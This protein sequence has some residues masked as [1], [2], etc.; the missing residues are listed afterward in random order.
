MSPGMHRSVPSAGLWCRMDDTTFESL[1]STLSEALARVEQAARQVPADRWDDAVHTGDGGWTRRELL[2][3][4]AAND[5]RQLVRIRVG[6]GVA[7]P[8]DDAALAAEQ[9]L[10]EWN[11]ARVDER[12][13]RSV[14][15]LLDEMRAHR[16]ELL[17]LLRGL[18]PEQRARPMPY[19]GE[20]T[21][22]E[23]MVPSLVAH[24]DLHAREL[25]V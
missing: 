20:P 1:M 7:A 2:A 23:E 6:A 21:P 19:R 18:T 24:L 8:D 15:D 11:Q 12:R 22:L 17:A 16:A 14:D 3:H 13:R 4:V 25:S 10:H 5:L 9:R